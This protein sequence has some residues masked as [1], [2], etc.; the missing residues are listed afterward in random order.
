M[1][2][3]YLLML[4]SSSLSLSKTVS[5]DALSLQIVIAGKA[6]GPT[7]SIDLKDNEVPF[8]ILKYLRKHE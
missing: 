5:S 7:L 3:N 2:K 8:G 1:Q 6:L 4:H